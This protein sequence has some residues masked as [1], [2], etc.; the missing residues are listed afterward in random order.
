MSPV[1]T[2][3]IAPVE[4]PD[5][6]AIIKRNPHGNWAEVEA[7]RPDYN[8]N[9]SWTPT[10]TPCPHWKAGDG[11]TSDEWKKHRRVS[12][13]PYDEGRTTVQNYK[14]MISTTVPRPIALVGT[15]SA[16]GVNNLAPF[17]Y[18]QSVCADVRRVAFFVEHTDSDKT[19]IS[20]LFIPCH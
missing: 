17:S 12:I 4:A 10:K 11:A 18:F 6:E 16:D 7:S 9:N 1:A 2:A 14:L 19:V 13:A 20:R 3:P 5:K 8:A 15:K